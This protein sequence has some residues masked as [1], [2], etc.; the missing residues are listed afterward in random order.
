MDMLNVK[1]GVTYV[2]IWKIPKMDTPDN[3]LEVQNH[4]VVPPM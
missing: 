3:R 1:S 2:T 4:S